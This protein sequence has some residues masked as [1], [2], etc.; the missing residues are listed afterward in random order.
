MWQ[1][2]PIL[3]YDTQTLKGIYYDTKTEFYLNVES[4]FRYQS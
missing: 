3:K 4:F 1:K 2:Q